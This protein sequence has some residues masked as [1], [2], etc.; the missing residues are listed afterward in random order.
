[1][2]TVPHATPWLCGWLRFFVYL[3][4]SNLNFNIAVISIF[5]QQKEFILEIESCDSFMTLKFKNM[6][7][8]Q[9]CRGGS[10]VGLKP[11]C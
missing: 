9:R 11:S 1:M 6:C 4:Y 10:S 7:S 8:Q 5:G 3:V 2:G